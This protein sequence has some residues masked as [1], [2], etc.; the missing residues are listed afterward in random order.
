[1]SVSL[2]II[3][4]TIVLVVIFIAGFHKIASALKFIAKIFNL[5]HLFDFNPANSLSSIFYLFDHNDIKGWK[6]W[7]SKQDKATQE[8]AIA[9]LITH[10]EQD[11]GA[12][13]LISP[14]A[15]R[16]LAVFVEDQN[17]P[18]AKQ[19]VKEIKTVINTCKKIWDKYIITE[20]IYQACWEVLIEID[21]ESAQTLI[22]KELENHKNH[23]EINTSMVKSFALFEQDFDISTILCKILTDPIEAFKVKKQVLEI[24][25]E[26]RNEEETNKTIIATLKNIT[27]S[28]YANAN[29]DTGKLLTGLLSLLGD[30]LDDSVIQLIMQVCQHKHLGKYAIRSLANVI[31]EKPD[32]F[33]P[34]TLY[35]L[36]AIENVIHAIAKNFGLNTAEIQ[37]CLNDHLPINIPFKAELL[38]HENIKKLPITAAMNEL[39][40]QTKTAV[41]EAERQTVPLISGSSELDK[42]HFARAIAAE[43]QW[44][45][46]YAQYQDLQ[47]SDIVFNDFH[48]KILANRPILVYISEIDSMLQ[49]NNIDFMNRIKNLAN[50]SRTKFIMTSN[51]EEAELVIPEKLKPYFSTST[52]DIPELRPIGKATIFKHKLDKIQQKNKSGSFNMENIIGSISANSR[53]E[54]DDALVKYFKAGLLTEGKVI[55]LKRFEELESIATKMRGVENA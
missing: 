38:A 33:N 51:K 35:V 3:S 8:T 6:Q 42:L 16:A 54:Y 53:L 31:T 18:H 26:G 24:M 20:K 1:M 30:N 29:D 19:L 32:L 11:P 4:I 22:L 36:T 25:A 10:L 37:L 49:S 47:S 27:Q 44:T 12:W 46:L 21:T 7:I 52:C 5:G 43:N 50:D 48:D 41:A 14:E 40:E 2:T 45:F 23:Y 39:Y 28:E 13:G 17:D 9:L 15:I 34:E 55:E